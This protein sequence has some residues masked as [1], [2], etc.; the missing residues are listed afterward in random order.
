MKDLLAYD[1]SFFIL[2]IF[3]KMDF[4]FF[5]EM[6]IL[7]WKNYEIIDISGMMRV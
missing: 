2:T 4:F 5:K 1:Y 6:G 3:F 7:F